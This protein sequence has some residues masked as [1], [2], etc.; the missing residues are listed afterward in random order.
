MSDDMFLAPGAEREP[1]HDPVERRAQSLRQDRSTGLA[2]GRQ[3]PVCP[4]IRMALPQLPHQEAV[5]QHHEVH[6][7]GLALAVTQGERIKNP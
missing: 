2:D 6:V 5:R 7:P 4:L 3:L 1:F